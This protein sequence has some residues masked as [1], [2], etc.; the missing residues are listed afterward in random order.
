MGAVNYIK[1]YVKRQPRMLTEQDLYFMYTLH[2]LTG[3]D[4]VLCLNLDAHL[5]FLYVR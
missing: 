4:S 1:K 3:S 2:C 5:K